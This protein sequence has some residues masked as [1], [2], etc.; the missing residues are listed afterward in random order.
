MLP[1]PTQRALAAGAGCAALLVIALL[2]RSPTLASIATGGAIALAFGLTWT[3]PQ[4]GRLRRQRLEFAW[5]HGHGSGGAVTAGAPFSVKCYIRNRSDSA[6]QLERLSPSVPAGTHCVLG[7]GSPVR[8][9]PR[10][11]VDFELMLTS[12]AVGRTVLQGLSVSVPGVLGLFESPIYFPSPLTVKVLPRA[13]ARPR[14]PGFITTGLPVERSGQTLLRQRGGGTELRELRDLQP[15]DPFKAIAWKP[16]ARRG[17]LLVR[18]VEREVQETLYVIVDISGSMRG[19]ELGRRKLDQAIDIATMKARDALDGGDRVGIITVDGRVVSHVAPGEGIQQMLRVYDALLRAT[20]VV[21]ADLTSIEDDDVVQLVA[22]YMRRQEGLEL[23][24]GN[25]V[26]EADVAFHARRTLPR[27]A[28]RD[29]VIAS[30]PLHST[31]RRYCRHRGI[32]LPYRAETLGFAK[33]AGLA[34]ALMQAAGGTRMPRSIVVV[35]D[36]DSTDDVSSLQRTLRMLRMNHHAIVFVWPEAAGRGVPD[37]MSTPPTAATQ[38]ATTLRT[39]LEHVYGL[40][41]ARR[42]QSARTLL[43]KLG[44]PVV[45]VGGNEPT[46][47]IISRV[48]AMVRAA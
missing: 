32:K 1:A 33:S 20:E 25:G 9:P 35:S 18:E 14:A 31:L 43:G 16:S 48:G 2:A 12:V 15:G 8:V 11:R 46:A 45:V 23:A 17:K 29:E 10:S 39:Q 26:D 28:L 30:S 44:I 5:W 7:A 13:S 27:E 36:L 38:S 19:G 3:L 42:L 22:R 4:A 34:E 24:T 6:F 47:T 21:D 41:E 37:A 40:Q